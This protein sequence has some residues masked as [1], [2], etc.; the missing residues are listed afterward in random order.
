M[1]NKI[2]KNQKLVSRLKLHESVKYEN[3]QSKRGFALWKMKISK[4]KQ[5]ALKAFK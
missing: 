5:A 4:D 1:H 2:H 3:L